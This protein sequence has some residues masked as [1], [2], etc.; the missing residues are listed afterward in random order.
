MALTQVSSEGIK[1]AQVKTVDILDDAVT[2][3]KLANSI[4][5][6]IAA[7][8][9]KVTN[10]T[11]SGE[12]T[13]ATALT[14]ADNVVDEANLKA[15]NS[16]TNDY[17]LTAKSSAAGGLTWAAASGGISDIVSDTSPQLGGDLDTNSFEISLD[18]G[19]RVK[20]GDDN[21]L[22]IYH[23]G[24]NYIKDTTSKGINIHTDEFLIAN[25]A[26]NENIIYGVQD[27]LSALYYN[28]V[29]KFETTA[30]GASIPADADLRFTTGTWTG[31][32]AGK[33]QHNN[34]ML[35]IQAG[36]SGMQ[37]RSHNGSG[38]GG[39]NINSDGYFYPANNNLMDI[40]LTGSRVR[41]LY[42]ANDISIADNGKL[43]LGTSDDLQISHNG[44]HGYIDST[45]GKIHVRHGTDNAIITN[46]DGAV[47]LYYDGVLKCSTYSD[48]LNFPDV[49]TAAFG[50]SND[51]KLYHYNGVNYIQTGNTTNIEVKNGN[52]TMASFKADSSVDLYYDN[53]KKFETFSGGCKITS[54]DLHMPNDGEYIWFGDSDDLKI[55]HDGTTNIIEGLNGNMSIRPKAGENGI[56]LR[57][58]G[59][60]DLYYDD[61]KK[62]ETEPKG[63]IVNGTA[64]GEGLVQILANNGSSS[65]IEFGDGDDDDVAQIWYDHYGKSL[66]LR[67]SEDA[68]INLYHNGSKKFET[69]STGVEVT[70]NLKLSG[71]SGA[72]NTI[73]NANNNSIDICGSEY[74][75]F[76]TN[77]TTERARI[78]ASGNFKVGTTG[79]A[80][81]TSNFGCWLGASGWMGNARNVNGNSGVLQNY[82]NA[83]EH[84]V[85]GDGDVY[86]TNNTYGQISDQTLKQDIVDAASQWDDIKQ[87]KVRKFRFKDRPTAPLQIGVV[88]QEIETISPGLVKEQFKNGTDGDQIKI[89]KYS[90]LYMKAIKAL[91]EA[92]TRIETL[93]T[94]VAALKAG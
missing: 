76:R 29:K 61:V 43:L 6:E 78:D 69:T 87:V 57:N 72:A 38:W 10:A 32:V 56:L 55:G 58:N 15:D 41:D 27:G 65:T 7:N 84:R 85:L 67:T 86:N 35:Y 51:M 66:N 12:V 5:T 80:I 50:A 81:D 79:N 30:A 1:D 39:W 14:I 16:P 19:H 77:T 63:I 21:D 64:S 24:S 9:A 54:G 26:G 47:E 92:I 70:G 71:G 13:G 34:N 53:S 20:F 28:G 46:T 36:S 74:I 45:N 11:H 93:E 33:I 31:E 44:T 8:T 3:D 49:G 62:F 18:D 60:V 40:G 59:S 37:F 25:A 89:V 75:Y 94:E 91:Q 73:C 17:V 4:N 48:G 42:I 22:E 90:V 23:N 83:G 52:E 68:E 88:A 2:A 82:G